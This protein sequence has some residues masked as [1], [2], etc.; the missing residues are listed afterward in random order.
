MKLDFKKLQLE[1]IRKNI[2]IHLVIRRKLNY[3]KAKN[4]KE[5]CKNC[6]NKTLLNYTKMCNLIGEST[7][8]Y[9]EIHDNYVCSGFEKNPFKKVR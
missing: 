5:C 1:A 9:S 8:L 3:R 6:I 7:S 4:N 2:S